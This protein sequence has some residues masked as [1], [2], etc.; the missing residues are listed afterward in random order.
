MK[1]TMQGN[2]EMINTE[3]IQALEAY[4]LTLKPAPSIAKA[5]GMVESAAVLR[6]KTIFQ[7]QGCVECHRPP[8]YTSSETYDVGLEE[9]SGTNEYNPPSLLG[10]SQRGPFFHDNRASSLKDVL[11][12]FQHGEGG[13][14]SAPQIKDLLAFL[15]SL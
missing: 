10:V 14:L 8:R 12:R 1:S 15:R 11:T 4:L 9:N 13:D 7:Q 3:N 6:G 5:R 2:P